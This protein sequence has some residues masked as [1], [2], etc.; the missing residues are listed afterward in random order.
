MILKDCGTCMIYDNNGE[1]L[2]KARV[3]SVE[4]R[5]T[6]H[7]DDG[8]ELIPDTDPSHIDFFDPERI[9]I[10]FFDSQMGCIRTYSSLLIRKNMD[11]WVLEPWMAECE[12]LEIIETIQRQKDLRVRLEKD[13]EFTS[14]KHGHFTG[15]I[16]NISV[17]GIMLYTEMP[18]DVH[19]EIEFRYCFQKKEY[20]IRAVILREQEMM[21]KLH[22]YG[23]QF[24]DLTKS[25]ERDIR[26]FVFRQQLKQI[27]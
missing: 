23:C 17:G 25:A 18:L 13:L 16:H 1:L 20:E 14:I 9:Q 27:W 2:C 7:F 22:V 8:C 10:D 24:I 21:K 12:I 6:L 15:I 3:R 5:I 4:E 11:P 26:Q 19:E